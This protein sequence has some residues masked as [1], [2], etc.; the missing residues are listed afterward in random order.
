[1]NREYRIAE[2]KKLAAA[3][4]KDILQMVFQAKSGHLGGSLSLV[5]ILVALYWNIMDVDPFDPD[6]PSRDRLVL[7]KGHTTPALYSALAERGF[8]DRELLF[9]GYRKLDSILQGHPD[10]KKTPGVDMSSGSLGL[11]LSAGVGMAIGAKRG[12]ECFQVYVV[13]GDGEANEGG[14]WEAAESAAFYQLDNL[15][16][17]LDM[18]GIQNDGFTRQVMDMGDMCRKWEA[19]GWYVD[20]VDGHD[21]E[22][23]T[24][25]VERAKQ[26]KMKPKAILCKTVKG[27]GISFMEHSVRFHGG[28]PSEAEYLEGL[29]ELEQP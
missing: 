7:S 14:I 13:V 27:K 18:N 15:Y 10:M 22:G 8:F 16:V 9:C 29:A 1:M 19:F 2:E 23:L 21:I 25:A 4:R 5:E 17:L 3:I 28:M 20:E 6:A 26:I 11:G 12:D 24:E